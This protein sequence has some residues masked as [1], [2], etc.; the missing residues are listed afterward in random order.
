MRTRGAAALLLLALLAA[1]CGSEDPAAGPG[2]VLRYAYQPGDTLAYEMDA[3]LDLD[4]TAT[5]NPAAAAG[6]D[7][8]MVMTLTARLDLGFAVGPTP[9]T[10]EITVAQE[11]LEGGARMTTMGREVLIPLEDLAAQMEREVVVVVDPQGRLVSAVVG[12]MALPAQ[13]LAGLSAFGGGDMLTP[14][15]FGPEFPEMGLAVGAEWETGQ[16]AD[17]LG[18][19]VSQTGKHRVVAEEQLLGRTVY[20]IDSRITTRAIEMDLADLMESLRQSPE[21]LGGADPAELDAAMA[22]FEAMGVSVAVEIKESITTM[23]T[24][25]DPAA[26]I[27]VRTTV[28]TPMTMRMAMRGVPD[29]DVEVVMEMATEQRLTLAA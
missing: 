21:L 19:S 11:V 3:S 22:Q 1:S 29:G 4:M 18:F 7:A 2:V 10:I 27:V 14:Q 25:F 13:M 26:G 28:E 8:S 17:V 12:G 16:S 15:Q 5:G 24:W 20:R 9:D 23:T 6:M